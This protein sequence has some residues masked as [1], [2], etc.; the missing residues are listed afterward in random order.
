M[1]LVR[2]M[3]LTAIFS[4]VVACSKGGSGGGGN[5]DNNQKPQGQDPSTQQFK[6]SYQLSLNGCDTGKH[7]FGSDTSYD[8][9]RKQLCDALQDDKLNGSCAEPLRKEF[10]DKKCSGLAWNPKYGPITPAPPVPSNPSDNIDYVTQDKVRNALKFLL[11]EKYEVTSTLT[12]QEKQAA[13]QFAEDLMSC[14]LS[15]LGPKCLDYETLAGNYGGTLSQVDGKYIFYSELKIKGAGTLVALVFTVDQVQPTVKVSTV[16]IS[17]IQ[18]PRNGQAL[19]QYLKDT[20]AL[21]LLVKASLTPDLQAAAAKRLQS[22]RD[23]REL[24]HM[25]KMLIEISMSGNNYQATR[26]AVASAIAKNKSVITGTKDVRY[27]EEML[28]FITS[29]IEL[30]S[31]ALVDIC[32]GLLNSSSENMKE[33]AATVILDAQPT[34]TDLKP[35]VLKA[36]NNQRWDIR[37]KAISALSKVPKTIAE[38]SLLVSKVGDDDGDVRKVAITAASKISVNNNHLAVVRTLST[39][40]NWDVRLESAKLLSRINSAESIQSLIGL[41]NDDDGDVRK[42]VVS[43]LQQKTLGEASVADLAKQMK[44]Q[45]WDVRR[46]AALFLSKIGSDQALLVLIGKMND[47][48]GDVRTVIVKELVSKQIKDGFIKALADNYK[49]QNW[50]VRR[51]VSILLA[52]NSN[53]AA[54]TALISQMNDDDGDVRAKIYSILA[55]RNLSND[56]VSGLKKNFSS[57]NWD[58]RRDVA[59]LLGKIKSPAS[60]EALQDQLTTESDGDVKNQIIASI[61]AVKS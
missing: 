59:K 29:Q 14:G 44:S 38:E 15:Y 50:D 23:V 2:I 21:A 10:F 28:S 24:F 52:K 6:E 16:E 40:Q 41:M 58:V 49:S 51:D 30:K 25:S 36:L 5:G 47:D 60:L 4:G 45:N 12:A 19:D 56:S 37:S 17:K 9:V 53:F 55:A 1:N 11:V 57:Q 48:D 39:N 20:S 43:L 13:T 7:I 33:I 54:T 31:D 32:N 22:P 8:D 34:R 18:K 35:I 26:T 3:I 42:Q 46:D 27:Q 61:K